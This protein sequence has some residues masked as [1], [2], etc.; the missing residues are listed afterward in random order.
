MHACLSTGETGAECHNPARVLPKSR[1]SLRGQRAGMLHERSRAKI[2]IRPFKSVGR[3]NV[4][5]VT[6]RP[7]HRC[8]CGDHYRAYLTE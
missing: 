7:G 6:P 1:Q 4:L 2:L 3:T 5:H 8:D